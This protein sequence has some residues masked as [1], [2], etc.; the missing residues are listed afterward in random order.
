M[1]YQ[2]KHNLAVNSHWDILYP[3][4][5]ECLM[6]ILIWHT[7]SMPIQFHKFQLLFPHSKNEV[8]KSNFSADCLVQQLGQAHHMAV[9]FDLEQAAKED[10]LLLIF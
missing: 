10:A 2:C 7:W 6:V 5:P 9:Y 8:Q 1:L 3:G 4:S